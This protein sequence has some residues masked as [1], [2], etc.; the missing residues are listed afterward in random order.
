MMYKFHKGQ[1]VRIVGNSTIPHYAILGNI[2]TI[3][4]LHTYGSLP[5]Y[6][7][8]CKTTNGL[9]AQVIIEGDLVAIGAMVV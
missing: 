4:A 1:R 5:S 9:P 3:E 8:R 6:Y 2:G 7:V